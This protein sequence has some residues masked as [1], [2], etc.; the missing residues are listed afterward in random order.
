MSE[1]SL[2]TVTGKL[3][4][5]RLRRLHALA[6]PRQ[7]GGQP[8][9]RAGALDAAHPV[10]RPL[11]HVAGAR[12]LQDRPRAG[13]EGPHRHRRRLPQERDRDAGRLD[14]RSPTCSI[15]AGTMRRCSSARRRSAPATCWWRRLKSNE[16]RRALNQLSK[17]F[18]A[19]D[20]DRV[21]QRRAD[22]LGAVRRGKPAADGRLRARRAR[23]RRPPRRRRRRLA[24]TPRSTASR[25]T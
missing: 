18:A 11:R 12:P 25:S 23:G 3:N 8:Q 20:A 10:E 5:R 17:Q 1:I 16:L 22:R 2:E 24:A 21:A 9:C 13:A 15:A 7:E 6:A 14:R 19:L 4:R